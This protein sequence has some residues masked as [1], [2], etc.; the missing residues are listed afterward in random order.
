M[1]FNKIYHGD[2]FELIK[3][4]PDNTI[5]L[6]VT[7][8]PY[9]D[10][11]SY[12]KKINV[13]HP[14]KYVD[15]IIPLFVEMNRV[16]KPTGSIIFNIDDKCHKK[17]RHTFVFDMISRLSKE[18]NVKLY[19]YYI[20]GKKSSIPNGNKKRLNHITEWIFHF[21]KDQ[22]QVKWNMDDVREPYAKSTAGRYS[23]ANPHEYI[24]DKD[25]IKINGRLRKREMNE[26]GKIPTNVFY[27]NTNAVTRG[28]WHPAPFNKEIPT[29]FIKALTDEGDVI[30][31]PFMGSGTT[32]KA[33]N[34]LGREWIGFDLNEEYVK[35]ANEDLNKKDLTINDFI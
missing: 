24:T 21:V 2:C 34:D 14:D 23:R 9:A 8:P 19:D 32:A 20:W 6:V 18:T 16:I 30:L 5:D 7:S 35:R 10:T 13:L 31:D 15:W 4:L 1:K 17:L 33:S 25:G 27:F 29:W 11:K 22:D 3:Q 26:N 28:N 12:G